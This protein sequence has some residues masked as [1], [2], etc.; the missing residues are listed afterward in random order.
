MA[1]ASCG[2]TEEQVKTCQETYRDLCLR[3]IENTAAEPSDSQIEACIAAVEQVRVCAER[4]A[5]TVADC[6]EAQLVPGT[7]QGIT[8]C[9]ILTTEQVEQLA[10]CAFAATPAEADAGGVDGGGAGGAGG[11]GGSGGAG[12]SGGTGGSGA[13]DAGGTGGSGA[14]GSGGSGAGGAGGSGGGSGGA[15]GA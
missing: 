5:A 13:G 6:P 4:G 8:P 12:G 7:D 1:A 14:G 2:Y 10:A 3:G 15:G 9:A 11:E